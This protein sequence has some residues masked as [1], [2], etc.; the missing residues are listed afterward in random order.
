MYS[1]QENFN[2]CLS[3]SLRQFVLL[4][5]VWWIPQA[6]REIQISKYHWSRF[7]QLLPWTLVPGW[8][9][10]LEVW[11]RYCWAGALQLIYPW[12]T[13]AR[14]AMNQERQSHTVIPDHRVHH[15]PFF[16]HPHSSH[17]PI[18][19]CFWCFLWCQSRSAAV[20]QEVGDTW[21]TLN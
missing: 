7:L 5:G 13:L 1:L 16:L 20:H 17:S 11:S 10:R 8:G 12:C 4:V 19:L 6:V 15:R 21:T 3:V 2:K 14:W 9:Q 18:P